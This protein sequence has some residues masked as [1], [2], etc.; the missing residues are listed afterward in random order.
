MFRLEMLPAGHGDCLLLEYG[1]AAAP[2]RVLIDAG[3]YYSYKGLAQ[4]IDSLIR[5]GQALD[6]F[7]VTH[8]DTDHIDGAIKVLGAL[9]PGEQLD[10]VWFNGWCHLKPDRQCHGDPMD[11]LGPLHGEMLS[12]LILKR[13]LPWNAA[14]GGS[15]VSLEVSGALPPPRQLP[16]GLELTL[17][18]PDRG[19]LEA[20]DAEWDKEVH[21]AGMDPGSTEAALA[22]LRN[23]P[24]YRPP[25]DLLGEQ[26]PDVEDLAKKAFVE[27]NSKTN[28]SGI[29]F[30]AEYEGK[31]CLCAADAHPSVLARSLRR[32]RLTRGQHRLK[33]DAVKLSHHGSGG[34]TS[35]ELLDQIDCKHFLVST[36]GGGGFHHPHP[37][38]I[39]RVVK[40]GG[41]GVHLWFNYRTDQ[42]KI[43]DDQHLMKRYRYET[44]YPGVGQ[45]GLM[46]PLSAL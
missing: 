38:A 43:W 29:A 21:A 46:V 10:D 32:L 24:R 28:R 12:A 1:D 13:G 34:N 11:K 39:A 41:D 17:L 19:D 2:H 5:S 44:H 23:K 42:T 18:S 3:P 22:R 35:P 33:V 20:L 45:G 4:H 26:K 37:E 31:S 27:D 25:P 8:I 16:G 36:N 9:R 6:L 15:P 40:S 30:L 7:V 14:F